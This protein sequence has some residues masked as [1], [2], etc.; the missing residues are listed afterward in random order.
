MDMKKILQSFD[1][2]ASVPKP[3]GNPTDMRKFV[4]I[5]KN[6]NTV[7]KPAIPKKGNN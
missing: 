4:S 5:V 3:A 1:R 2:A 7:S 6:A